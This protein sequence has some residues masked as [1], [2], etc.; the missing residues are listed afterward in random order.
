MT[1]FSMKRRAEE[2]YNVWR[3][4]LTGTPQ[5][6]VCVSGSPTGHRLHA[7]APPSHESLQC[8][9]SRTWRRRTP[10]PNISKLI[11][12]LNCCDQIDSWWF[13]VV[14]VFPTCR[15]H[16]RWGAGRS[17][18]PERSARAAQVRR[19][20]TPCPRWSAVNEPYLDPK[21]RK[22]QADTG[23]IEA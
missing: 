12:I 23:M 14:C 9:W 4:V 16:F 3:Q 1:Y 7:A 11:K 5:L 15:R 8:H 6:C 18:W 17:P 2:I 13:F 19:G 10:L 21:G 20:Q 22:A